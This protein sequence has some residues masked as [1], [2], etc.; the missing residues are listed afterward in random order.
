MGA[1]FT[2]LHFTLLFSSTFAF[3]YSILI[4][5]RCFSGRTDGS[6]ERII[7]TFDDDDDDDD[8]TDNTSDDEDDNQEGSGSGPVFGKN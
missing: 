4:L 1:N 5:R 8:L 6:T 2:P 7:D 3:Q